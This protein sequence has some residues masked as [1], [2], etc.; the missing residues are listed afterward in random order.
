MVISSAGT[1]QN[2]H[3]GRLVHPCCL[4]FC[5]PAGPWSR[6]GMGKGKVSELHPRSFPGVVD[7]ETWWPPRQKGR[8]EGALLPFHCRTSGCPAEKGLSTGTLCNG[9][10]C[11]LRAA[12]LT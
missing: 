9:A 4:H 8:E 6:A 3:S 12:G 7:L 1:P 2:P 11:M 5:S 10:V